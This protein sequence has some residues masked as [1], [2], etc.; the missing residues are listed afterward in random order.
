MEK[1][2]SD[3]K[4]FGMPPFSALVSLD[5]Y[6]HWA[7]SSFTTH[8]CPVIRLYF[9]ILTLELAPVYPTDTQLYQDPAS[10]LFA[11]QRA[12]TGL[13]RGE[14]YRNAVTPLPPANSGPSCGG[15]NTGSGVVPC[16]GLV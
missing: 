1:E 3:Q 12:P 6:P 7:P 10:L 14:A 2:I 15:V 9:V 16:M 13:E 11:N 4:S 5:S 8:H